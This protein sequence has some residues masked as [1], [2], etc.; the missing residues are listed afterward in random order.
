MSLNLK[1]FVNLSINRLFLIIFCCG[2]SASAHTRRKVI[3]E[4]RASD[5]LFCGK[6]R[7]SFIYR[8][9]QCEIPE[10]R[11][12]HRRK[13]FFSLDVV[14][15]K[16]PNICQCRGEAKDRGRIVERYMTFD[17]RLLLTAEKPIRCDAL[18][19]SVSHPRSSLH[20]QPVFGVKRRP[21]LSILL[22][23]S[24]PS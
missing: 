13:H 9:Y 22:K 6:I 14:R 24:E 16:A 1:R 17:K 12:C 8:R 19:F 10:T 4:R 15:S 21:K 11:P 23:A 18:S 2:F 20:S 7:L 5:T 3:N